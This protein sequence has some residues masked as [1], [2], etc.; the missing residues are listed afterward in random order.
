MIL[1]SAL[2]LAPQG[3]VIRGG[4]LYD[5]LGRPPVQRDIRIENGMIVAVGRFAA[6][7]GDEVIDAKGLAVAPGFI[8]AH[9]HADGGILANLGAETQVRQGITTA[10]VGEDGGSNFPLKDWFAKLQAT[11]PAINFA[12]FV[13]HGTV[14]GKVMGESEK[15]STPEERRK[16]AALVEEE[17]KSGAL[18]LSTGLEYQPGRYAETGEVVE[19][20]KAARKHGGIYISHLRNEDNAAIAAVDELIAIAQAAKIP[21]QINHIKLGSARVWGQAGNVLRK[22]A[23]ARKQGLDITADIYPYLYWQSTIRVLIPTEDWDDRKLWEQGLADV[24]GPGNV[25]LTSFSPDPSWAGK[26]I[27]EI[28]AQTGKDPIAVIQDIVNRTHRNG[29]QGSESVVVTAMSDEDVKTFMSSPLV[30]FCSDGGLKGSHPRG[31]GSFPRI[32]GV[33]VREAHALSLA[34]AIQKMTSVPAQRFG[35]RDRGT[36]ARGKKAD[37]VIFDPATVKDTA[38]VAEP[39]SPPIGIPTVIVNG[40][41]VLR[42]GKVT[43]LTPGM[44]L[45]RR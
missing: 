26:T 9:S 23:D 43:G 21:A 34:Q 11:P 8:D 20:A 13:G 4:M 40:I 44:G 19:L 6:K 24:G 17:M 12:S 29:N 41:P 39:Q 7:R 36:I 1:L 30:M 3:L 32:L 38:T 42:D 10:V 35:F 16:M 14:R 28:A 33:Y 22:M 25:R 45:R 31:A 18:G 15:K 5:G 37:L 2:F 27:A